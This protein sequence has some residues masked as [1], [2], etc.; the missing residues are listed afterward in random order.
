M[1]GVPPPDEPHRLRSRIAEAALDPT[2]GHL[3][4]LSFDA[5]GRR[6]EPLHVAPW[7]N[8]P[9]ATF[10]EGI[11]PVERR[12]AGDFLCAPFGASDVEPAPPH[13]WP[14]N[15]HWSLVGR[16]DDTLH[17]RLDRKVMG[18]TIDK[19]L[20]LVDE[21]PLLYQTHRIRD[22]KGALSVAHHPMV[23]ASEGGRLFFSP[24]RAVL[25]PDAPLEAGRHRLACGASVSDPHAVPAADGGSVDITALPIG[26]RHEDFVTLVEAPGH[27]L[28]WSAVLREAER[29]IVFVLK[30][31]R[32][33]PV[34]MFWHSNG[35]RD[36]A[37]WN[38]R[39][40]GV[41][42]IEDGCAAGADGHRTALADSALSRLGVPTAL[43]LAAGTEHRIAQ[44]IGAVPRPDGWDEIGDIRL[45]GA[46]LRIE[47]P[48]G[49]AIEL[50][51]RD[52][53]F[54]GAH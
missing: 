51:F 42:G 27:S 48:G 20:R 21:A 28:G 3:S 43:P 39:H 5:G 31:P 14:A 24:K 12:L 41:L 2:V 33:L 15:S 29:D 32:V 47:G 49:D 6:L 25:T 37:P 45:D 44:V 38:G 23:R 16:T 1:K 10:P 30:D 36:H 46:R 53:F 35:G 7:T 54:A 18:A 13:G 40:S 4:I 11:A 52:G 19:R 34:T 26:E 9:D 8:A 50:P 17:L 22:G